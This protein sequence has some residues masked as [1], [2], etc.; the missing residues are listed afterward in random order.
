MF[1]VEFRVG[2]E[3]QR[4]SVRR[5][6]IIRKYEMLCEYDDH[7]ML[8]YIELYKDEDEEYVGRFR[9]V[10]PPGSD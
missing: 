4:Q 10:L 2:L 7:V 5:E 3:A 6:S 1:W 9:W 8:C